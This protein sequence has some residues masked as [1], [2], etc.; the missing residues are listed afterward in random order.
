[1]LLLILGTDPIGNG[2]V[3]L[4]P[5]ETVGGLKPK[6]ELL[7]Q[8]KFPPPVSN[9][10]VD[11]ILTVIDGPILIAPEVLLAATVKSDIVLFAKS[12]NVIL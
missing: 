11:V 12:I 2:P 10:L 5:A 4:P 6:L 9:E 3:K 7:E 1:M 8:N